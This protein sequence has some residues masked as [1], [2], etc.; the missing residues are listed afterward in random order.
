VD[1]DDNPLRTPTHW[2]KM[3]VRAVWLRLLLP[4]GTPIAGNRLVF[5]EQAFGPHTPPSADN[6]GG[7]FISAISFFGGE[8]WLS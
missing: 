5:G 4:F 3:T 1:A 7:V 2:Q 6:A 8:I